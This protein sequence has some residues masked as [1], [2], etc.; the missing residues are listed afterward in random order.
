VIK[1]NATREVLRKYMRRV[2]A[3]NARAARQ[4][5]G[6]TQREVAQLVAGAHESYIRGVEA[7]TKDVSLVRAIE[8]ADVLGISLADLVKGL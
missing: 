1:D 5:A 7:G 3:D 4:R 6:M 8:I 2:I